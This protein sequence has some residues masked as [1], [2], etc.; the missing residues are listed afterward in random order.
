[1]SFDRQLFGRKV[2]DRREVH[3]L[4]VADLADSTGFSAERIE[5]LEL[6]FEEPTGDEVLILAS[7][8]LVDFQFFLSA[9]QRAPDDQ[10]DVLYRR[11][12]ESVDGPTRRSIAEMLYLC[13]TE[14]LVQTLS[15]DPKPDVPALRVTGQMYS[16]HGRQ[17][18]E[19]LRALTD[20]RPEEPI[21]DVF[22]FARGLG[23]H[24]FRRRL[25]N[26]EISGLTI[27]HPGVGPCILV[28]VSEDPYRQRFTL[29]HEL[30][31]ALL[32][33]K[34]RV[35]VSFTS[36][37]RELGEVRANRFAG[38]LLAPIAGF[39]PLVRRGADRE[40]FIRLAHRLEVNAIT[41]AIQLVAA[42][43]ISD[44]EGKHL[45]KMRLPRDGKRD[46]E[47]GGSLTIGQR[48][49]RLALLDMG[50]SDFYVRR[51]FDAHRE[52][53]ISLGRLAE[54][55]LTSVH[56]VDEIAALY[57]MRVKFDA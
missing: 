34:E 47:V 19:Q 51:C 30:A 18:A 4:S 52:G 43:V 54:G 24:V 39:A 2:A 10:M 8:L 22:E 41:L 7:V 50:L 12:G 37:G 31:H 48:A 26:P 15:G 16:E 44:A 5:R 28:N 57:G 13:E 25:P 46:P 36:S 27:H 33:S 29:L 42:G 53:H 9:D 49:R 55:L 20:L 6:G 21:G 40:T 45:A 1:M 3:G 11:Y 38:H 14:D 32:D 17:A 56:G 23:V 35:V